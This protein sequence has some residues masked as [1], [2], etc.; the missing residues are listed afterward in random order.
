MVITFNRRENSIIKLIRLLSIG[1][2][3]TCMVYAFDVDMGSPFWLLSLTHAL[4]IF[5]LGNKNAPVSAPGIITLNLV[6]FCRYQVVP[7]AIYGSQRL[8]RY[9][10]NKLYMTEAVW[11]M[12]AE[13]ICILIVLGVTGSNLHRRREHLK[14]KPISH[15][16]I[17]QNK[18]FIFLLLLLVLVGIA[19]QFPS[20][21]SGFS[22]ITE[23]SLEVTTRESGFS[24]IIDMVW[25][26]GLVWIYLY[27][28][29]V[30]RDRDPSGQH[31][32]LLIVGTTLVYIL[33]TFILNIAISRWYS[34]VCFASALFFIGKL[35]P[36]V[37]R[38]VY[39]WSGLPV[40]V[41]VVIVSVY[42]NTAF[43]GQESVAI[44]SAVA[45][46]FDSSTLDIYFAGPGC[47]NN[48]LNLLYSGKGDIL[49][50]PLD[51]LRNMPLINHY[52]DDTNSTVELYASMIHRGDM[53]V[54]LAIQSSIYF[55]PI[56]FGALSIIAV[57]LIRKMDEK[58]LQADD[59]WAFI[60]GFI[61]VWVALIFVLNYT[62][63]VSWL[64]AY[65]IPMAVLFAFTT[66]LRRP[67]QPS[68]M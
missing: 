57:L 48:G 55:S 30:I 35:F 8:S 43:M 10:I 51:T 28:L 29:S 33:F 46:L 26:S 65:I 47:V 54:P 62:I 9:S 15:L 5:L 60:Y 63:C 14:M 3:V 19:F 64:Y 21:V 68:E 44:I 52:I 49:S 27:A 39:V 38:K 1:T 36:L 56:L 22:L 16:F 41:V 11:F 2:A 12:L 24:G 32:V 59:A 53:I 45:E 58:Y 37:Q 31:S 25:R 42:K 18:S 6:M 23:G 34:I 13:M 61:A 66:S 40:V 7:L 50:L 67:G 4:G 17:Q 20:L